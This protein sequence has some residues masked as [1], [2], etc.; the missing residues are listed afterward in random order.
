LMQEIKTYFKGAPFYNAF[1]RAWPDNFMFMGDP[2]LNC[3]TLHLWCSLDCISR[4][5]GPAYGIV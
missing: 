4:Q 3:N 2:C 1:L 5:E